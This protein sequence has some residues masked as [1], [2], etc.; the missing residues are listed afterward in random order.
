MD[1]RRFLRNSAL[2]VG[3][4][5]AASLPRGAWAQ[6]A[7]PGVG[8]YGSIANQAPDEN[9]LILPPGFRSRVVAESGSPVPGTD[10][11]W[12]VYPD[13]A[14][15][16]PREGGGWHYVVNSEVFVP[17]QLGGASSISFDADGNVERSFPILL[18]TTGNCAGGPTPW[19]SWL[20][21]EEFDTTGSADVRSTQPAGMVWEADP[22]ARRPPV[23]RPAMGLFKHEAAAVDPV[24]GVVYMTEDQP[25]GLFYRFTP[26]AYPDLDGGALEAAVVNDVL[27][28]SWVP[29]P[30]PTAR[31]A[32]VRLQVDATRFNGGEGLWYHDGL[33]YFTTKHDGRV[34]AIHLREQRYELV[35]D[36]GQFEDPVL[37][38]LDNC[39]VEPGSGDLYV[40]EDLSDPLELVL[41]TTNRELAP[42]CR[43]VMD[44]HPGSELT[45]PCFSPDGSRLFFSSQRGGSGLASD[46]LASDLPRHEGRR[47]GITYEV[48]GPFRGKTPIPSQTPRTTPRVAPSSQ[49][50]TESDNLVVPT[51][52]E[53]LVDATE[54]AAVLRDGVNTSEARDTDRTVATAL[55]A[56]AAAVALGG[57]LTWAVRRRQTPNEEL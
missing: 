31:S 15:C 5:S 20:S 26:D 42:F 18:G 29:L 27:E 44:D 50:P 24:D 35:Y 12:P 10:Y 45:G 8:P 32:S 55:G 47:A 16:F 19:G 11:V 38:G 13:G 36:Q 53:T 34:H 54:A 7:K 49:D 41:V 57:A 51:P 17:Q 22:E 28:V 39:T 3:A 2:S 30:D 43:L 23:G 1:R 40:A 9:G 6:T 56:T 52:T 25:D 14:A 48:T 33:V 37:N 4:V 46:V 21:C